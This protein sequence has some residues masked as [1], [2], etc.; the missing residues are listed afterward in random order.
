MTEQNAR[1]AMAVL[2]SAVHAYGGE[3]IPGEN[4]DRAASVIAAKLA[5]KDAEC[6]SIL[7]RDRAAVQLEHL[8]AMAEKDAE[9]ARKDEAMK[10]PLAWLE[11]WAVH[12]GRC[13][14]NPECQCGLLHAQHEL[15]QALKPESPDHD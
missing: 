2:R 6:T 8:H 3:L 15:R 5:E 4:E 9:I 12:V 7:F 13:E 14:D 1:E 10:G 11:R